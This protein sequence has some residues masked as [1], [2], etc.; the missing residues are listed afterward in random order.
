MKVVKKIVKLAIANTIGVICIFTYMNLIL[1]IN[2]IETY[3][4]VK[5]AGLALFI[6]LYGELVHTASRKGGEE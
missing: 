4:V 1:D 2:I 5:I 3:S 6:G